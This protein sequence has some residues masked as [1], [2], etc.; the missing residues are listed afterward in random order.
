MTVL[1]E[2][3]LETVQCAANT[4]GDAVLIT[5]GG[6]GFQHRYLLPT[7][8]LG[9]FIEQLLKVYNNARATGVLVQ[10]ATQQAAP[11]ARPVIETFLVNAMN[12]IFSETGPVTMRIVSR[13][14]A[15]DVVLQPE[16]WAMLRSPMMDARDIDAT[17]GKH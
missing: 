9:T 2:F 16:Q 5:T 1:K 6:N 3:V 4:A 14:G 17:R 8:C 12:V 13:D 11:P 7:N 10:L 15:R